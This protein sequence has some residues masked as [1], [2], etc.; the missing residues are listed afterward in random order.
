M[1]YQT[2]GHN[3]FAMFRSPSWD[4][5]IMEN[6]RPELP[7][8]GR[9]DGPLLGK[10][11]PPHRRRRQGLKV[12]TTVVSYGPTPKQAREAALPGGW[13]P[14]KARVLRRGRA[15]LTAENNAPPRELIENQPAPNVNGW[16]LLPL[17][18]EPPVK[19]ITVDSSCS[20]ADDMSAVSLWSCCEDS[21]ESINVDGEFIEVSL[22][23]P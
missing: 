14:D 23:S 8:E 12:D 5:E 13:I 22:A 2:Q 11:Q 15:V 10:K 9:S 3:E 6:G 19:L 7:V 21:P 20:I 16:F 4:K 1:S 17:K 18:E